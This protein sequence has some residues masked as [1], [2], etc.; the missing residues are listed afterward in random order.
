MTAT[1]VDVSAPF[2]IIGQDM[3]GEPADER[4]KF[5]RLTKEHPDEY[6]EA[7]Q[8]AFLQSKLHL[9]RTDPDMDLEDRDRMASA[10]AEQF[11]QDFG[12]TQE[13]RP[14]H[15]GYG[16]LYYQTF[17][18]YF[19]TGTSLGWD[20]ICPD[21]PGG[22]VSNWLYVTAMN[23]A[24]RGL[25]AFVSYYGQN[26][27]TFSV[28]DWARPAPNQLVVDVPLAFIGDYRR[29]VTSHGMP[30]QVISVTNTTVELSPGT[31]RNMV[32]LWN[33]A[34][35]RHDLIYWFDY[36]ATLA[37]QTAMSTFGNWGPIVET[38][39]PFYSGT[40][41]LGSLGASICTRDSGGNWGPWGLL[42]PNQ[43]YVYNGNV[44]FRVEFLDSNYNFAV[45]S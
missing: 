26:W 5:E 37:Q 24:V 42:T 36:A 12:V 18:R 7:L 43:S 44:G 30:R 13:A 22:N 19:A 34:Q 8:Q 21:S 1:Y 38:F 31:W 39:Q 20:I 27:S 16:F 40:R 25:E 23:R 32:A 14:I 10:L 33:H 4:E 35:N 15:V 29:T 45:R 11:E 17:K 2:R 9:A 28:W 41:P 6:A 3:P